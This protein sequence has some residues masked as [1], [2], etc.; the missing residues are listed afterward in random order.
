MIPFPSSRDQLFRIFSWRFW[1]IGDEVCFS[2]DRAEVGDSRERIEA[3]GALSGSFWAVWEWSQRRWGEENLELMM[4][5]SRN[6]RD[7]VGWG[8]G[9]WEWFRSLKEVSKIHWDSFWTSYSRKVWMLLRLTWVIFHF[10]IYGLTQ[11][12]SYTNLDSSYFETYFVAKWL[13]NGSY[14]FHANFWFMVA[15][16]F[17]G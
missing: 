14:S 1:R 2:R 16:R 3:R 17:F 9:V 11:A 10:P 12:S 6:L 7:F 4:V 15:E 5:D 13:N 8:L